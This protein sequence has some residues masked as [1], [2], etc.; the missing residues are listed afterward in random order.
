MPDI[1][2]TLPD[3]SV[4]THPAGV[5]G[6]QIAKGIGRGLARDALAILVDGGVRDLSRPIHASASVRVLTWSDEEGKRTYWHSS[7]HLMAEAVEALFPGTRFGVGPPI[8]NGFYYDMDMGDHA[9]T[10]QDLER[11]EEKMRELAARD[12]PYVREVRPW[13]EVVAYFREKADPYKLELLDGL[14][15]QEITLYHQGGFTDLCFGPHIPSTGRIKALKLLSV[16]GAYWRGDERNKMLQRVYGISFPAQ[17]ELEEHLRRLEEARR[18]DHRK[19]GVE[20]EL[21]M[22]T[23]RVGGGLPLW[24]PRG[25]VLRETLEAFLREEQ[26]K[27]GYV[28]V[29]TPHIGKLDLYRTSGHYPYYKESQ[30]APIRV[31]EEE[32]LL[33]P[34]NCPHHHQVYMARPRS[35]RELPL[36]LAEFG[37]V[38]RYEQSGE[39]SG[40]T[41]VRGFT[42]DDAHIYCTPEQLKAEIRSTTE[43]TGLVFRTFGM[44]VRTR[45]SFRDDNQEKFGGKAEFWER[46]QAEI[47]EVADEMGLE[48]SIALGEASFYG[49]KIDFMVKDALGRIWQLGTVQVDYV[50]PERFGLEYTGSDGLPHR[51]VIIHRAPFG[52]LER[53]IGLLI[54]H[55]AGDFPVWLAPVQCVLLPITDAQLDYANKVHDDLAAAGVRVEVDARNEKVGYKIREWESRKVPYMLVLG[56]REK[57]AGAVSVR[58]HTKGDLGSVPLGGF[59]TRILEEIRNRT[60]TA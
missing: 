28:Q 32:Y 39:L 60:V 22:L 1:Q 52:S 25:T 26:R 6:E 50:M 10:P 33:K 17:E 41:R 44:E 51:P 59:L 29:V 3:G 57:Q 16:A 46:A 47:K 14:K 12:V 38:Y 37:T 23:P 11:L 13:E 20:L 7:A 43:L 2:I 56:E 58:R 53:F 35:Y 5:T 49:P 8:E 30:F 34:M 40:L 4:R 21:F 31:E 9:L 19:L 48:Y 55:F 24:L 15:D 18:R 54:E 42:Q 45:L 27:R 36:R